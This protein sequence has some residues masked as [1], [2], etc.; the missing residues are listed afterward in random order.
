MDS[1]AQLQGCVGGVWWHASSHAQL[2]LLAFDSK[3][4]SPCSPLDGSKAEQDG[5]LQ[6]ARHATTSALTQ[7]EQELQVPAPS[8]L[9]L[10]PSTKKM[11]KTWG[12]TLNI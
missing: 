3:E 5:S 4:S 2:L 10:H 6:H 11:V 12:K 8:R 1:T 7:P 9:P